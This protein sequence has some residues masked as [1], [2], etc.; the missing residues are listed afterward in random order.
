MVS[1]SRVTA[2]TSCGVAFKMKY[3]DGVPEQRSGSAALFGSVLHR[4]L[5][6]WAP[7]RHQ[8]LRPLID[9]AWY[10]VTKGT[11]VETFITK[12]R[13]LST[14]AIA[15]EQEIRERRPE[16]KKVRMTGDWKKSDVARAIA[17]LIREWAPKLVADSPWR[18]SERDPLPALYDESVQW[19]D[20]Y[21]LRCH[22]LPNIWHGE[23]GFEEAWRGFTLKGYIDTVEPVIS[24][25][26]ELVA[27]LV[28]DY[29]SYAKEPA[30]LKDW[31]Q[32]AMY[33]VAF[34]QLVERGAIT[35]P[36]SLDEV[37]LLVGVDY[38]R[39]KPGWKDD[40][41]RDFPPRRYWSFNEADLA[42]LEMELR[43]YRG[44]VEGGHFLPAQK[45]FNPDFCNYPESCCL[46][47]TSAAGGGAVLVN[48]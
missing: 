40:Q 39:W 41:G 42:R 36:V 22:T 24:P 13:G 37:P 7:D 3:I 35:L 11:A 12:Y 31:R 5:E 46:R 45:N 19:A 9:K 1:P 27:V 10:D 4:G 21:Q 32:C 47:N 33:Y 25:E 28:N 15:L 30:E 2:L 20:T 8:D 6:W 38:L 44:I 43:A 23:F 18:F 16:V 17:K 48:V 26:G 34:L 29:K 14:Q